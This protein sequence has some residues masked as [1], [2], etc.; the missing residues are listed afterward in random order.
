MGLRSWLK[1]FFKPDQQVY[2]TSTKPVAAE[3]FQAEAES[4]ADEAAVLADVMADEAMMEANEHPF[5]KGGP[6]PS[7]PPMSRL[8]YPTL[9]TDD[10]ECVGC[11][12]CCCGKND[13]QN[14]Q[15]VETLPAFT[16]TGKINELPPVDPPAIIDTI[17]TIEEVDEI[18][19]LEDA[20]N[21]RIGGEENVDNMVIGGDDYSECKGGCRHD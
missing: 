17:D 7:G 1:S 5:K 15:A 19:T 18:P 21:V 6:Y 8:P 14:P 2:M 20:E 10:E 16:V 12:N 3:D 9:P 4:L 11:G 13:S